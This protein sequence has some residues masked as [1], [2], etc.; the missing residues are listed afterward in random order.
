M[1][2]SALASGKD[3]NAPD[4]SL[5][6]TSLNLCLPLLWP[7]LMHRDPF[8]VDGYRHRHV[9]HVKFVDGFHAQIFKGDDARAL[10][11]LRN[12]I[13]GSADSHQVDGAVIADGL[14]RGWT[15]FRLAYHAK[16]PCGLEHLAGKFIHAGS[17]GRARRTD[18]F[19]ADRIDRA[20]VIDEAIGKI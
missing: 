15:T 2:T 9:L 11:R 3:G 5:S 17:R 6:D 18:G 20:N 10:D 14:D 7:S 12:K 19:F 13:C 8:G 16:E 1:A 4:T